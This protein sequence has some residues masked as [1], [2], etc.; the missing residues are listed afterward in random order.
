MKPL[1]TDSNALSPTS[2]YNS[3]PSNCLNTPMLN[4]LVLAAIAFATST[5]TAIMGLGGGMILIALM[6]GLIAPAAIVPVH[7]AT[8][9]VSN[10]SRTLFGWHAIRWEFVPSFLVGSLIGGFIT[11]QIANS[12]NTHYLPLMIAAYILWNVWGGGIQFKT[13]PK[14]EFFTIG[15]LQTG[16]G[17][18][19]GATGPMGQSTLVRKGLNRDQNVTT[20][21]LFVGISH[22]LKIIF[23]GFIGFSFMQYWQ[24]MLSM[25]LAVIA[26]SW[27][28]TR[29]RHLIPEADFKKWLKWLLTFLAVRM[30]YSVFF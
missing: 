7:A 24:V 1:L 20:S 25:S 12:I 26:G 19:V 4:D 22:L 18:L 6:P 11:A 27:V 3:P 2:L 15:L 29:L 23:F 21:A 14:G 8:Q 30:I 10:S 28:G 16:L 17:M 13:N 5:L 9:L